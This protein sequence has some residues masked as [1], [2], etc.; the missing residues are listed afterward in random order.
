MINKTHKLVHILSVVISDYLKLDKYCPTVDIHKHILL[1]KNIPLA[2][3]RSLQVERGV[4][5]Q[6]KMI[7]IP[8]HFLFGR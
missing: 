8:V 1:A 7:I 3:G 4:F 5:E 6:I 2:A